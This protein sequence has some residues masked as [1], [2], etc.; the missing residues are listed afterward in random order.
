MSK[1]NGAT[2]NIFKS[3]ADFNRILQFF[4]LGVP[5][6]V[7]SG[8]IKDNLGHRIGFL[9]SLICSLFAIGIALSEPSFEGSFVSSIVESGWHY[10]YQLE[11]ILVLP[12]MIFNY[13]KRGH[14]EAF[15][16]KVHEFDETMA[17][18]NW[19]SPKPLHSQ[20][21]RYLA[22]GLVVSSI[23]LLLLFQCAAMATFFEYENG[24]LASVR[25]LV[26]LAVTEFY[27][28]ISFQF[29]FGTLSIYRRFSALNMN[30]R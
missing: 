19:M 11:T 16:A 5:L 9:L 20:S 4:G 21:R 6:H 25:A 3:A 14:V 2:K 30:V 10:Q 22:M 12:L 17:Q 1:V 8:R 18:M 27:L 26:F 29:I 7:E 13:I 28:L 24:L 15:L 23:L